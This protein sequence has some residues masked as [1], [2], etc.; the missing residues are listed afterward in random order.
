[1]KNVSGLY[2]HFPFCRHLCNYCDFYK[3]KLTEK[4]QVEEF[5]E[6]L[7][8]I[9]PNKKQMLNLTNSGYITSTDLADYLVKNHSIS[10]RNAYQKTASIV[11]YAEKKKKKLLRGQPEG[12]L[13]IACQSPVTTESCIHTSFFVVSLS[14]LDVTLKTSNEK[15]K[16]VR[17]RP[18]WMPSIRRSRPREW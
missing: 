6:I 13:L 18:G 17:R 11:N 14:G 10:F 2:I 15:N 12:P 5:E 9:T 7:K 1:M 16:Y 3:H 8:N 4:L